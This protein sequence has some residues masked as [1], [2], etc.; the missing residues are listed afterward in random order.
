MPDWRRYVREHLP[1]LHLTPEREAEI[2]EELADQLETAYQEGR[3]EGLNERE[4]ELRALQQFPDWKAQAR[5]LREATGAPMRPP[6]WSGLGADLKFGLRL[7]RRQPAFTATIVLTLALGLG[8]CVAIY[9][10][11][12]AVVLRALPFRDPQQLVMLWEANSQR[13]Y[14]DNVVAPANFRDWQARAQSFAAMS[15]YT[16][17][18]RTLTGQ[19]E[20]VELAL[21][22]ATPNHLDVLGIRPA[23]GRGFRPDENRAD[24]NSVLLGHAAWQR[25]FS[26]DPAIVGRKIVLS[27]NP[28]EVIGVLPADYPVPGKPVDILASYFLNPATD[29]RQRAGRYMLSVGRLKPGVTPQQAQG[30]L[31]GI[32]A[33]LERE[34]ARFN[35][36]W[37]V[38]VVPLTFVYSSKVRTA[39]WILMAAT[40]F[41]V[42]IACAN[43]ANLL[44]ARAAVRER[45]I[46]IRCSV[47]ASSWQVARQL[48]TESLALAGLAGAVGCGFAYGLIALLKRFAPANVPRLE[49]A[50]LN[51]AVL[52]FALLTTL[53]T[54]LLFGLAPAVSLLRTDF[55][56]MLKDGARGVMGTMRGERWRAALV[57]GEVALA[58]ILLVGG[59]LLLRAFDKIMAVDTGFDPANLLTVNVGLPSARYR[60]PEKVTETYRRLLE[61]VRALPG[62]EAASVIVWPPFEMGMG[63]SFSVV[64]RPAPAPGASPGAD[65]RP[66]FPGYFE[67]MR[68][69]LRQGRLLTEEDNRRSAAHRLVVNETLVRRFFAGENPLGQ[70]LVVSMGNDTPGEIVGVVG[71]ARINGPYAPA[72]PQIYVPHG[73]LAL[74]FASLVIRGASDPLRLAPAVTREVRAIDPLL[75]TTEIKTMDDRL[76]IQVAPQRFLT[77]LLAAFSAIALLLS[78]VGIYGVMSYTVEQRTHEIGVRLALGAAP[79]QV[80]RWVLRRGL[81][82]AGAGVLIGVGGAAVAM[83]L[84]TQLPF[85]VATADPL[86]Y[87]GGVAVLLFAALAAALVPAR[88]ATRVDPITALRYE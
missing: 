82:L 25:Y 13:N 63:T 86:G 22:L 72:T 67:T 9:S 6:W 35:K 81:V 49:D 54:G 31:R 48:L 53:G 28:V 66:V 23:L 33:Q 29:Y 37:T 5:D 8:A 73:Q 65:V 74:G 3:A 70:R 85:D 19:G 60:E 62:V 77:S 12:E 42:L 87:A 59:G 51:P 75:P 10:L 16:L 24:N 45:E 52:G 50:S 36:N 11:L 84:M 68:M 32:A 78:V 40:G 57:V 61:R 30:E 43:I 34:H 64:G 76:A 80:Q 58:L 4:A 46:A 56:G 17:M 79:A 44:L 2:A 39:L 55:A 15:A 20:P 88:R 21:Q 83:R 71:D 27:G 41:V 1:A 18:D 47:G 26:A 69:P 7:L 38:N 14:K